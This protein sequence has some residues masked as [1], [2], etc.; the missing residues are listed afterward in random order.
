MATDKK[1]QYLV[2]GDVDG[3][4]KVWDILEYCMHHVDDTIQTPP[5]EYSYRHC[6]VCLMTSSEQDPSWGGPIELFLVPAS[7]PRLV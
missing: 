3:I 6:V 1:N 4:I 2:T 5:R 7:A